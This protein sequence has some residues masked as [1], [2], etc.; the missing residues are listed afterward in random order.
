M[1]RTRREAAAG[2]L[3]ATGSAL[4]ASHALAAADPPAPAPPAAPAAA[5]QPEGSV[6]TG[7]DPFDHLT[8]PVML[9]GQGPFPFV[10]DTGASI[11]CVSRDL[12][13]RLGLPIQ[14]H[15]RVHTIVGEK[16]E[17]MALVD[18]LRVGVR[19]ERRMA[20]LAIP[21][22]EPEVQGVLA[23]DWIRNQ[24]VTLDFAKGNLEFTSSHIERS[25]PGRV[26][27]PARRRYGQLTIIDAEL[28][29]RIVN[30]MVDSG[31][32]ASLCNTALLKL[33]DRAQAVPAKRELVHMVS[34]IGEP[35][36]G[37]LVYLPFL[38]LGGLQLGNVGVVHSDAHAFA[39]WGLA[40]KPAVLLGMDL[41]RQFRAVSLDFG[42]SQVRFDL[43]ESQI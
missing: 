43:A 30:A 26:V 25:E 2:L 21:I 4:I 23:V 37:E 13:Q 28:G 32:E 7:R 22:E 31:S 29:E 35:F 34:V 20:A 16:V 39:I 11:S 9:N 24:R 10:V 18:E 41:L 36:A 3:A 1:D 15:R 42:R 6:A 27:V 40:D 14:E 38:Q 33:L 8:A 5:P 12:A 17:P 19:R